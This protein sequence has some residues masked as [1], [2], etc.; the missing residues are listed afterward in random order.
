MIRQIH[1]HEVLKMMLLSDKV[2]TKPELKDDILTIFGK[3]ARFYTCSVS[4]MDSD[5]LI[6]KLDKEGN[7]LIISD[8]FLREGKHP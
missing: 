4:N 6:D 5:E 2:Y 7:F 1:E 8:G 3:E